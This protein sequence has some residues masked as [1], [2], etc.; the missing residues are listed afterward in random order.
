MFCTDDRSIL[1]YTGAF[2]PE[3]TLRTGLTFS[4]LTCQ[5]PFPFPPSPQLSLF[6]IIFLLLILE[7]SLIYSCVYL[8]MRFSI[9]LSTQAAFEFLLYASRH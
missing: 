1:E 4:L 2:A 3:K 9:H 5:F 7:N 6:S 8:F